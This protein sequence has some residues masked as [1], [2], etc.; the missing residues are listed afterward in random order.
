MSVTISIYKTMKLLDLREQLLDLREH[1]LDL[2]EQLL[3]L[4][5]QL[6]DLREQILDLR[7]QILVYQWCGFKSR[8]GK[9]KN[10]TALKI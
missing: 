10:L 5:E 3:D 1:I 2:R 9:N 4:R 6:L 7:E 8:R